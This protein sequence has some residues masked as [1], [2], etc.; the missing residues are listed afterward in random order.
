MSCS[1]RPAPQAVISIIE[2]T[3]G[4]RLTQTEWHAIKALAEADGYDCSKRAAN[5][6]QAEAALAEFTDALAVE[7]RV[8]TYDDDFHSDAT[9]ASERFCDGKPRQS[10]LAVVRYLTDHGLTATLQ[11]VHPEQA[12]RPAVRQ[13]PQVTHVGSFDANDRGDW[14]L[15]GDGVSVSVN[16]EAWTSIALLGGQPQWT[17]ARRDGKPLRFLEAHA[18][19]DTQRAQIAE[20]GKAEGLVEETTIYTV[21]GY[22]DELE[23]EYV[24]FHSTREE[25]LAEAY[26]PDEVAESTRLMFV[27]DGPRGA[28]AGNAEDVL[29]TL[30]A[31]QDGDY[32]GVW[33]QDELDP[34]QFTAP[35]GVIL[36]SRLPEV[37]R[38]RVE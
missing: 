2:N 23:D 27:G 19:T 22:D 13:F 36:P 24:T 20:W 16:P 31:E 18:L 28:E 7:W 6:E 10:S 12:G 26:D 14:S 15:E 25:A 8:D 4:H 30:W 33:W 5:P 3:C 17:L 29:L 1:Q 34:S 11:K 38:T 37:T 21:T 9:E 32:D 35:R